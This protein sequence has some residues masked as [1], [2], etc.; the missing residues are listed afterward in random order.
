MML[1]HIYGIT[2]IAG[3]II[4]LG[5]SFLKDAEIARWV[6]VASGWIACLIIGVSTAWGTRRLTQQLIAQQQLHDELLDVNREL[7]NQRDAH[8]A[9]ATFLAQSGYGARAKARAKKP[10]DGGGNDANQA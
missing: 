4:T 10:D 8:L 7:K 5:T 9:I 2:G 1:N 6:L 3:V